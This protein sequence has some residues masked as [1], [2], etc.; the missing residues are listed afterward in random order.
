MRAMLREIGPEKIRSATADDLRARRSSPTPQPAT[1]SRREKPFSASAQATFTAEAEEFSIRAARI[2]RELTELRRD[3]MEV[4][5]EYN[6]TLGGELAYRYLVPNQD[7]VL[8]LSA[9]GRLQR[10]DRYTVTSHVANPTDSDLNGAQGRYPDWVRE[11]YLTLPDT[12]PNRVRREA[13]RVVREAGAR[14]AHEKAQAIERYVRGF[15]YRE[16]MPST[17]PGKDFVDEFLFVHKAGYCV[18][19]ASA[20]AVMLRAV[21][22]PTR[23]A[24]GFAPGRYDDKAGKIVVTESQAHMWPQVYHLGFGWVNYEPTPIREEVDRSPSEF[25]QVGGFSERF[26]YEEYINGRNAGRAGADSA[27]GFE[28]DEVRV[29]PAPVRFA[30]SSLVALAVLAVL[31]YAFTLVRLRG[32]RG[33]TRQYA[34]LTQLGTALRVSP[35][36]T[37][38]PGEYGLRLSGVLPSGRAPIST[39]ANRY[40]EEIFGRRPVR[41]SELEGEWRQVASSAAKHAPGRLAESLGELRLSDRLKRLRRR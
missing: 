36:P 24:R 15:K 21:D 3:G 16:D 26:P 40:V 31:L 28:G 32:L 14:T 30:L 27:G 29:L 9:A 5:Y 35:A 2:Q 13:E 10:G 23:I 33:A 39:I 12:V 25:P 7:D 1:G 18:Y 11:Q 38:T 20:M 6:A 34:K 19:H 22:V 17:T 37:Q 41:D 4:E 8:S